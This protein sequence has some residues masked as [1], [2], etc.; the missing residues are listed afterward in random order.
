VFCGL[1][2]TLLLGAFFRCCQAPDPCCHGKDMDVASWYP[3]TVHNGFGFS[4]AGELTNLHT[5]DK[6]TARYTGRALLHG[7]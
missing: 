4:K 2:W 1:K 5:I 6:M 3:V 7:A